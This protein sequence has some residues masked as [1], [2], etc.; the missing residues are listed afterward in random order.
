MY[1]SKLNIKMHKYLRK[2]ATENNL[3]F[4]ENIF[5]AHK[6]NSFPRMSQLGQRF[7]CVSDYILQSV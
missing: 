2:E 3:K 6:L 1:I 4:V 5:P 7:V